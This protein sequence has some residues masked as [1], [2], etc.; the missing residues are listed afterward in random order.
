MNILLQIKEAVYLPTTEE[1]SA[2]KM[3]KLTARYGNLRHRFSKAMSEV[4][5][6]RIFVG[7]RWTA[8]NGK[9]RDNI[10][11][12]LRFWFSAAAVGGMAVGKSNL[13]ALAREYR[14]HLTRCLI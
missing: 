10:V 14:L 12:S 5:L 11:Q 7:G 1:I 2:I 9:T 6:L 4:T 13:D 8:M 3:P